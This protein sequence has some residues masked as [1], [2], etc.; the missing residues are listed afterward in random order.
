MF[1]APPA[2]VLSLV[3]APSA[4]EYRGSRE[5]ARDDAA[6]RLETAG[7]KSQLEEQG[8]TMWQVLRHR[9]RSGEQVHLTFGLPPDGSPFER[10]G[11]DPVRRAELKRR[12]KTSEA[13]I[14][15]LVAATLGVE[16]GSVTLHE[17][18][19]EGC[20]GVGCESCLLGAGNS[21]HAK[22]WTGLDKGPA[23]R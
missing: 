17:R 4:P 20:C 12:L 2:L 8:L 3:P 16:P 5:I 7:L 1:L 11:G 23:S 22:T 18:L 19:I 13:R 14:V 15:A 21:R 6:G 10:G 9:G